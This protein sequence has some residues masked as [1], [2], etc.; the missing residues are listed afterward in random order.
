MPLKFLEPVIYKLTRN[1]PSFLADRRVDE[2]KAKIFQKMDSLLNTI[3]QFCPSK[4]IMK[5]DRKKKKISYSRH[6]IKNA[7]CMCNGMLE[8]QSFHLIQ[9]H[10]ALQGGPC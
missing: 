2:M 4:R 8:T 7:H 1:F 3:L 5:E 6:D 9:E 10:L